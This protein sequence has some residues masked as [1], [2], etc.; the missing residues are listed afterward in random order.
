MGATRQV[1]RMLDRW[2]QAEATVRNRL[3]AET[4]SDAYPF[5]DALAGLGGVAAGQVL[6]LTG[7]GTVLP[8]D[9]D[10]AAHAG[11]VVGLAANEATEGEIVRVLSGG[12][13]YR[14]TW[15]LIAGTVYWL[16][17]AGELADTAPLA[18]FVQRIGV[19]RSGTMLA[20]CLGEPVIRA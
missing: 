16:G 3:H 2:G 13:V 19:A 9:A 4:E 20:L 10:N 11:F 7:A 12:V 5:L 1:V 15:M 8:A 14:A 6:Y 18:G 17:N